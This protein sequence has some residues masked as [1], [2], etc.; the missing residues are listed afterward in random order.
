[1]SEREVSTRTGS[2]ETKRVVTRTATT[3]KKRVLIGTERPV[4][5][6]TTGRGMSKKIN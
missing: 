6:I 3:G 1:M 2:P 5:K 4:I